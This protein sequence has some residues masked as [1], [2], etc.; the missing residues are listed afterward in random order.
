M[1]LGSVMI[2]LTS[3]TPENVYYCILNNMN[4]CCGEEHKFPHPLITN[5]TIFTRNAEVTEGKHKCHIQCN[6]LQNDQN[7]ISKRI[8]EN[9]YYCILNN[10]NFLI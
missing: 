8:P 6:Y 5:K 10:R 2:Y 7:D 3:R 9:I 1:D 4:I